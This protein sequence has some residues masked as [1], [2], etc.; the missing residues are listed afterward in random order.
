MRDGV[1]LKNIKGTEFF[2]VGHGEG[3][4]NSC[5]CGSHEIV[6]GTEMKVQYWE[7]DYTVCQ[8]ICGSCG[9]ETPWFPNVREALESW[10]IKGWGTSTVKIR[11]VVELLDDIDRELS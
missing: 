11:S 1:Q 3:M 5:K 8:A 6:C 9:V 7:P 10:N 2:V 4:A